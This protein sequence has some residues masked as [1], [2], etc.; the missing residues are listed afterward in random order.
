MNYRMLIQGDLISGPHVAEVINPATGQA[1]A[2]CP[3][4]DLPLL[5]R[6]V[7]A[8]DA[9]FPLWS[10]LRFEQRRDCLLQLADAMDARCDE[11]SRLLTR[12]QGKPLSQAQ[13]EIGGSIMA[14]RYFATI[15]LAERSLRDSTSETIFEHRTP[16]GVV[17]AITPWN[18]RLR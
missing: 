15:E 4:A 11:F 14:L 2:A 17:A 6:A 5:Q 8:A 10:K 7:D 16:L 12:E 18:R 13:F 1:F 3:R 9:A